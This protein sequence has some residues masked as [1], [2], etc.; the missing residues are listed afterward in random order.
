MRTLRSTIN[1]YILLLAFISVTVM[2]SIIVFIQLKAEQNLAYERSMATF[3]QIEQILDEN[4][5]ELDEIQ[6]E[7]ARTCLNNAET[8]ARII[9]GE[10]E[11]IYDVEELKELAGIVGVDEIHFFDTTGRIFAGTHPKYFDFTFDSGEQMMFFKPMLKDKS[12]R[13]VQDI[14]ANT[15]EAKP[16]QYSAIWNRKGDIIVQVGME[17]TKVMKVRAK[18][19][20]SYIFSLFSVNPEVIYCAVDAESGEIV[21]AT[22]LENVGETLGKVGLTKEDLGSHPEGFFAEVDGVDSFCVFKRVDENYIGR[23]VS[24]SEL[25]RRVPMTVFQLTACLAVIVLI[26]LL[27]IAASM[28]KLVVEKLRIIN[29]KLHSIAMGNRDEEIDVQDTFELSELSNYLN[30]MIRSFLSNNKKMSYVLSKTNIRIGVYEYNHHMKR[31]YFTEY[32]PELLGVDSRGMERL[33]SDYGAFIAFL[34]KLR[35]TP[36]S[37]EPGVYRQRSGRYVKIE[38]SRGQDEVFGVV[39]DMTDEIQRR[40]RIELERDMDPLTGLYNRRGM[41]LRLETLFQEPEKLGHSAFVVI[42]ADGLKAVNDT[43]GHEK[44]DIYL[45][46]TSELLQSYLPETSVAARQGGDEFLLFLYRYGDEVGLVRALK[47]LEE[48]RDRASAELDDTLRVPI[49]FSMGYCLTREWTAYQ[50]AIKEAD[51]RMYANKRERK[52]APVLKESPLQST[53]RA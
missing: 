45:K 7:Y 6:E 10:P 52:A 51:R 29:G 18:N 36:L 8:I 33:A 44:G 30:S 31:V 28:N 11:L 3:Q 14:T 53:D 21:G 23:I 32:L 47:A 2:L 4:R 22:V 41:D 13:L 17:P 37:G 9:E 19:E 1:R 34:E 26:L 46:K 50:D 12:L 39:I 40:R 15:A 25:Y 35:E 5:V 27:A 49:R 24:A 38:E 48:A 43:F 42:D 20:L 16:M